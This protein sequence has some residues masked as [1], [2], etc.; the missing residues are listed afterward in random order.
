MGANPGHMVWCCLDD[1][2]KASIGEDREV[3]ASII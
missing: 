3:A 2:L 1:S